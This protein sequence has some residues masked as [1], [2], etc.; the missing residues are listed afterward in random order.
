MNPG[1]RM[2]HNASMVRSP[3][4]NTSFNDLNV[5]MSETSEIPDNVTAEM[6]KAWARRCPYGWSWKMLVLHDDD[7][8]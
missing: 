4:I 3:T 1:I 8:L 2:I 7:E 5:F 6:E